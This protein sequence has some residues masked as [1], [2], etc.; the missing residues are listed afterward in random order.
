M[1]YTW[2][3]ETGL[4]VSRLCLGCMNFGSGEPWML[5]DEAASHDL[6]AAAMDAG[7]NFLER[8]S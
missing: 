8:V 5:D 7:V 3:G 4:E 2:P 1:E 6:L